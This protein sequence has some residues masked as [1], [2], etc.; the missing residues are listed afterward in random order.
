LLG[1]IIQE[2]AEKYIKK[3]T[4]ILGVE[5]IVG[6]EELDRALYELMGELLSLIVSAYIEEIDAGIMTDELG[7]KEAGVV[8]ER[9]KVPRSVQLRIG[10]VKYER[11]YYKIKSS[12]KYE[13]LAD[14]AVGIKPY[15]RIGDELSEALSNA[16]V[17]MPYQKSAEYISLGKVSA[18]TVMNKLRECEVVA[19]EPVE[20]KQATVL[21]IDADEDHITMR[22]GKKSE[23]RL[24]SVY[25]GIEK[26]DKRGVCKNIFHRSGYGED[27]ETLWDNVL[28]DIESR[29]E[30]GEKSTIYLHGDGASWIKTGLDELP[31]SKFVLDPY[32]KNKSIHAMTSGC[33]DEEQ[34]KKVRD[35]LSKGDRVQLASVRDILIK[36]KPERTDKI[37]QAWQYL[38]N[39]IDGI[40]IREIDQEAKNGGCTEPHISNVLSRRLSSRPVAWSDKTLSVLAPALAAKSGLRLRKTIWQPDLPPTLHNIVNAAKKKCNF[41]VGALADSIG[42]M[43]LF[44]SHKSSFLRQALHSLAHPIFL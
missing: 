24:V 39:H 18:Q 26:H 10:E 4:E 19:S 42:N 40:H 15:S 22:G 1:S 41:A 12:G 16:A 31:R 7:R 21:H 43:P 17:E 2:S 44:A 5:K 3:M 6:I 38:D 32:H 37:N 8:I 33:E 28:T 35:A 36:Q 34:K 11:T 13:Y 25:E 20:V 9:R 14:R 27:A 29:Y 23:V 30:L